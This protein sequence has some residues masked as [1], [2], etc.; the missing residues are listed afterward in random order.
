MDNYLNNYYKTN[1]EKQSAY[2]KMKYATDNEYK[3]R[4]LET[5]RQ[6]RKENKEK[7]LMAQHRYRERIRKEKYN[8]LFRATWTVNI[9]DNPNKQ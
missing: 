7:C 2:Y 1:K 6:Y 8:Y 5:A 3:N 9:I 4:I